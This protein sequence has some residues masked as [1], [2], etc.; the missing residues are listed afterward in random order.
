MPNWV[1]NTFTVVMGDA[2]KVFEFVRSAESVFDFNSI[3]PMPTRVQ[4]SDEKVEWE[5]M[6]IPEWY[7]WA[8]DNWGA[9]WNACEADYSTDDPDHVISF[10]TAWRPPE[11]IFEALAKRFPDHEI[12]IRSVER[13]NH[14][15][16]RYLLKDGE[17]DRAEVPC[18][19]F[20]TARNG[21]ELLKEDKK[22][23]AGKLTITDG[24]LDYVIRQVCVAMSRYYPPDCDDYDIPD[25]IE[26]LRKELLEVAKA[27]KCKCVTG[28]YD[29]QPNSRGC[30]I[31]AKLPEYPLQPWWEREKS[32][33]PL[34][35]N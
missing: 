20:D 19:C 30:P 22:T 27:P 24:Y 9:K 25:V 7:A 13:Q 15:H 34:E 12:R 2:K 5:G 31:H 3:T 28:E 17:M 18:Q 26:Y 10:D 33:E 29:T 35:N 32:P 8:C 16:C 14:W 1:H 21:K 6:T 11:P 23:P 4:K